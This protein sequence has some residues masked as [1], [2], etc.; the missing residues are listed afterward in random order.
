MAKTASPSYEHPE[1]N[2]ARKKVLPPSK[3]RAGLTDPNT[4]YMLIIGTILTVLVFAAIFL[5]WN[6]GG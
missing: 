3:A 1:E 2:V 6:H 4:L 5:V